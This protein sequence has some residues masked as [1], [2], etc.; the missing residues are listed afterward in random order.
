M[1]V[2]LPGSGAHTRISVRLYSRTFTHSYQIPPQMSQS[3]SPDN[4]PPS[5]V[6]S[7]KRRLAVL[8]AQNAELCKQPLA[9]RNEPHHTE[10]RS[11]Q[12]LV[13]LTERVEDLIAEFDRRVTLGL[14]SDT[15]DTSSN[16][17]EDDRRYRSYKKLA[18]RCPS[19]CKLLDSE[20][21]NGELC[22]MYSKLNKGADGARADDTTRLKVIVASWLM[23]LTPS[24]SPVIHGQ[25]KTGRG[26]N[27]DATGVTYVRQQIRDYH[28]DYR[29]T[30]YSWPA[31]LY[32]DKQYDPQNPTNSLFKGNFLLK[33]F[34]YIFTSPTSA[35]TEDQEEPSLDNIS[36]Q[37]HPK[38]WRTAGKRHTCCNVAGLL[39][40]RSVQPR[41]IA[42]TAVQLRFA[43]SSMGSWRVIDDEFNVQEFYDN[44]VDFLELPMTPDTSK[45][46][47]DLLLW[48][49]RFLDANMHL[50]I[51]PKESNSYLL[52][53][54]QADVSSEFAGRMHR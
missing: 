44:I 26:F 9:E 8:E 2:S 18:T 24:P 28:P 25:D 51:V 38:Q 22:H 1:T 5:Q 14:K 3:S 15:D 11:I 31:F 42:Y 39:N 29:V 19:V 40:M 50:P 54:V 6:T 7:L 52:L 35:E 48:W 27:N 13:C 12:R 53:G 47:D 17:T 32:K 41:S 37:G 45:E 23:Q 49:N 46:V 34:K 10:G 4:D 20:V 33:T 21:E 43:L 30:A 16:N 36:T